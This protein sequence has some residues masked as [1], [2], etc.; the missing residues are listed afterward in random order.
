MNNPIHVYKKYGCDFILMQIERVYIKK[1][2]DEKFLFQLRVD[3]LLGC[4][5][6][7]GRYMLPN[8]ESTISPFSIDD[9][10]KFL[11]ENPIVFDTPSFDLVIKNLETNEQSEW[12]SNMLYHKDDD[13][14][15]YF[16]QILQKNKIDSFIWIEE[17]ANTLNIP[18][19]FIE[20]F[21]EFLDS[22][23]II[24]PLIESSTTFDRNPKLPYIPCSSVDE[25]INL[26]KTIGDLDKDYTG[27]ENFVAISW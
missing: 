18:T 20:V 8:Q 25:Y 24:P 7:T 11:E 15:E 13:T 19:E 23:D 9:E 22:D 27:V 14:L 4:M 21:Y 2:V 17:V 16:S 10:I 12:S 5:D 26:Y 6:N 3:N 1:I